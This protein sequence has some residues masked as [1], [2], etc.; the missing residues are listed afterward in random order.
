[1]S[2]SEQPTAGNSADNGG[3][4]KDFATR[5]RLIK[6]SAVAPIV[7]TLTPNAALAAN[8]LDQCMQRSAKV[9]SQY[10]P[11]SMVGNQDLASMNS[12]VMQFQRTSSSAEYP[13]TLYMIEGDYYAAASPGVPVQLDDKDL[14]DHYGAGQPVHVPSI[15][16]VPANGEHPV[17]KGEWPK[18]AMTPHQTPL[19]GSCWSSLNG[20]IA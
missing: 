1:M 16:T 20:N 4:D 15:F 17:Y 19:H 5:R 3:A 10:S 11:E 8:S 18:V 12:E 9:M 7:A 2:D 13:N 14:Q 6:A